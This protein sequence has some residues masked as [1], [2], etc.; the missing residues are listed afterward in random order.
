[1]ATITDE[2]RLKDIES[3][4]TLINKL[5]PIVNRGGDKTKIAALDFAKKVLELL[6]SG[7]EARFCDWTNKEID[8]LNDMLLMTAKPVIFLL[9][10]SE[11]DYIRKK[12][13]WLAKIIAYLKE[14]N[15]GDPVIPISVKFE[16]KIRSMDKDEAAKYCETVG[17]KTAL[18][19]VISTGYEKLELINFF[20]CGK[21]EVH[22]WTIRRNTKVPQAAAV[23]H[24]D[25]EKFFIMAEVVAFDDL[26][27]Q[28]SE[29]GV[30]AAGRLQQRG[31]EYVVADGDILNIKHNAGGAP[32]AKKK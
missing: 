2:L 10:L 12:N 16:E 30:V 17:V 4:T 15:A 9:N 5:T 13:K 6:E 14:H 31:K 25:F 27:E 8:M 32:A 19:K 24:T 18:P 7:K 22:A 26:K 1:M 11:D 23:I 21:P 3:V 29:Q 20:T 28:G